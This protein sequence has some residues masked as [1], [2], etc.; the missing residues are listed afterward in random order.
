VLEV[1]PHDDDLI[2]R[3]GQPICKM[4]FESLAGRP[5]RTYGEGKANHYQDQRGPKLSRFFG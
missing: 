5:K 4:A 2:L 1:R 3:H